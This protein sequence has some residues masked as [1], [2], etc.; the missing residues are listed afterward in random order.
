MIH[1]Q[2]NGAGLRNGIIA[3]WTEG[4]IAVTNSEIEEILQAV[5]NGITIEIMP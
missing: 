1:G 4:C 3:D 2:P 5:P